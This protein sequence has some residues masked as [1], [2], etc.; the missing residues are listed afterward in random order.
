MIPEKRT[1]TFRAFIPAINTMLFDFGI[2]CTGKIIS[3]SED[4]FIEQLHQDF[5]Y[6][7]AEGEVKKKSDGTVVLTVLM[8]DEW[9]WIEEPHFH[10]QQYIGVKGYTGQHKSRHLN[11]VELCEGDIV[12]AMSQGAKGKFI[13]FFRQGGAPCWI[14]WPAWQGGTQTWSIAASNVGRKNGDYYDDLCRLGN[15]FQNPELAPK[16]L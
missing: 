14:L 11:E 6:D 13:I 1:P 12:E 15:I 7:N 16:P 10:L 4:S 5:E 2:G 3:L 8:G 9:I